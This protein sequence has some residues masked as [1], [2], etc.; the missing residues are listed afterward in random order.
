ME[1]R[2]SNLGIVMSAKGRKEIIS[3]Y[4]NEM[5][6]LLSQM[7]SAKGSMEYQ[8]WVRKEGMRRGYKMKGIVKTNVEYWRSEK[9]TVL[10]MEIKG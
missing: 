2:N 5:G 1:E 10:C 3:C 4:R 9:G 8:C 6:K 7:F